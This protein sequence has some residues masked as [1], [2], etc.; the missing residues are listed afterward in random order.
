M[1]LRSLRAWCSFYFSDI[2]QANY[3]FSGAQSHRVDFN[4]KEYNRYFDP[5]M[6][7]LETKRQKVVMV[8]QNVIL[9]GRHYYKA[10][11][12]LDIRRL[13]PLTRIL[14]KL[15]RPVPDV[16]QQTEVM[17]CL[18]AIAHRIPEANVFKLE[19]RLENQLLA[20]RA[21]V[22]IFDRI[23]ARVQPRYVFGLCYYSSMMYGMNVSAHKKKIASVDMQHGTQGAL[24]VAYNSFTKVPEN[25]Y[26]VLPQ[27]FWC[28]DTHSTRQ[29]HSW[30]SLQRYHQVIT[31]GNPWLSLWRRDMGKGRRSILYTMQP[32]DP[33]LPDLIL[34]AIK[35]THQEFNWCLRMH[36]RQ[37]ADAAKIRHLLAD[38]ELADFAT[39]TDAHGIPLPT[40]IN[41]SS[42]H[43]SRFSGAIIESV[44]LGV[45]SVTID[46][47]GVQAFANEIASGQVHAYLGGNVDEF[48][49]LLRELTQRHLQ[50]ALIPFERV[51]D[52]NFD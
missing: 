33:V 17:Q 4:G 32:I 50:P 25:G 1:Y 27:F 45:P 11:R 7:Y 29:I 16:S 44:L 31:G 40:A 26:E 6:D 48:V 35:N 46:E 8:E 49:E 38:A 19:K 52:N 18:Q 2:K 5:I 42:V 34:S 28:W 10:R 39:L 51:M 24:H 20:I 23:F 37:R 36:P 13:F 12:V 47:I 41:E 22:L 14:I 21:W 30:I 9:N 15:F 3:L 43:V